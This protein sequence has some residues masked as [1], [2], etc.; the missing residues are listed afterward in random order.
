MTK[1]LT[2]AWLKKYGVAYDISADGRIS[3]GDSLDLQGTQISALPDNLTVGGSLYLRGTQISALPD[4]LTV[5]GYLYLQG[6]RISA[7][8]DN[9]TVGGSL[10]LRG[11]Q[12]S[13]LP[14]NLT[15]GGYL[16]L[17]GTQIKQPQSI[18]RPSVDFSIKLKASLETKFNLKGWSIADGIL[19]RLIS[20]KGAI[21]KIRIV[22]KK[23]D[24][25]LIKDKDGNSAHGDT[26]AEARQDL[27]YKVVAK[28]D[29]AL[30]KKATGKEWVGIY[31]A[32]TGAC[33]AGVRGFVESKSID[34][35]ANFTAKE[36]AQM[37]QGS[38]GAEQFAEKLK[39]VA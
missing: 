39:E 38:F 9:L 30:P 15:V 2:A 18:K 26:I 31:R 10:D 37:V 35:D 23:N 5:G 33:A 36:I 16:D 24:S 11:T 17:Q 22:G 12:I 29:G 4:N 21:N 3:V 1:I 25:Y 27:I 8:P 32:V 7:L 14:D 34:L 28:F 19:S 13:A 20:T 6:T